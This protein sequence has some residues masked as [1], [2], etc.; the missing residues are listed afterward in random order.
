MSKYIVPVFDEDTAY[1]YIVSTSASS[2]EEAENR[3]KNR[4]TNKWDL[5]VSA[6]WDDFCDVALDAGYAIG[7]VS[8][9]EE[10]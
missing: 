7:E 3:I 4:L 8:D 10:F 1:P 9:I 5:E 6:D 2:L